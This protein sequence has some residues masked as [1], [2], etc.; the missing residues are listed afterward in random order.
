MHPKPTL[1]SRLQLQATRR[2][3]AD[4]RVS[5]DVNLTTQTKRAEEVSLREGCNESG[6]D[7]DEDDYE[8]LF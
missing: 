3:P 1:L 4:V 5:D 7:D 6:A 2:R 8:K